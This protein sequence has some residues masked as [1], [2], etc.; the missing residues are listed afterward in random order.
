MRSKLPR[1]KG[2]GKSGSEAQARLWSRLVSRS[3]FETARSD[4]GRIRSIST[5]PGDASSRAATSERRAPR[6]GS[7]AGRAAAAVPGAVPGAAPCRQQQRR[8]PI[9]ERQEG[10]ER[11][12]GGQQ[13]RQEERRHRPVF[14][15]LRRRQPARHE[16]RGQR[17][18]GDQVVEDQLRDQEAAGRPEH[19]AGRR[20]A[21]T[22]PEGPPQP[23]EGERR[24]QPVQP[25]MGVERPGE[26]RHQVKQV[27]GVEGQPV[28]VA[29]QRLAGGAHGVGQRQRAGREDLGL[30]RP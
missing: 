18:Q 8:A 26:R 16:G 19:R 2:T 20:A 3:R 11:I 4:E 5:R 14:R 29:E 15:L 30:G 25:E 13:E 17:H 12:A 23:V 9:S 28:G 6:Q 24:Q 10:R 22:Q 27:A 1:K 21:R 7:A